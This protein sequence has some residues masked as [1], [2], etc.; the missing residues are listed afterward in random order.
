MCEN[1]RA[2]S[3][4]WAHFYV[5]CTYIRHTFKHAYMQVRHT[6]SKEDRDSEEED[7]VQRIKCTCTYAVEYTYSG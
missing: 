7:I 4:D 5:W 6:E 1:Y 2:S 3:G